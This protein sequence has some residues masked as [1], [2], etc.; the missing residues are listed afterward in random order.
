[1][2]ANCAGASIGR[3]F[4]P[5]AVLGGLVGQALGASTTVQAA[6]DGRQPEMPDR[7]NRDITPTTCE[8]EPFPGSQPFSSFWQSFPFC[9][10]GEETCFTAT[11]DEG[12]CGDNVHLMAYVDRFDPTNLALNFAGDV[13]V[14]DQ[15]RS[16]S[17]FLP[18]PAS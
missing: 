12:N 2:A 14:S 4:V 6:F 15:G 11:F 7:L 9:N 3:V 17:S 5:L 1:M 16:P 8:M 18:P 13:G 10:T